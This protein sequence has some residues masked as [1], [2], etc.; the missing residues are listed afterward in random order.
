MI[1]RWMTVFVLSFFCMLFCAGAVHG[2]ERYT[3]E[4]ARTG[5]VEIQTGLVTQDAKFHCVKQSCG[6]L[7]GNSSGNVY[8]VTTGHSTVI[9]EDEKKTFCKVH[10]IKQNEYGISESIRLTIQGDVATEVQI[11]AKSEAQDFC[12]LSVGDVIQEKT[13]LRLDDSFELGEGNKVYALGFPD[14]PH[15]NA[16]YGADEVEIRL[17]A[18]QNFS[19]QLGANSVIQH[20]AAIS[21]GNSGGP[22]LSEDGYVIGMNNV[23]LLQDG[24]TAYVS[25]P[26]SEIIH[27][28]DNYGILY[29]SRKRDGIWTRFKELYEECSELAQQK[30]YESNSQE[31]LQV[32]LQEAETMLQEEHP[33]LL[34]LQEAVEKLEHAK[35]SLTKKAGKMKILMVILAG[36]FVLLFVRFLYLLHV[37][38]RLVVEAHQR[39]RG[40][41]C[42]NQNENH[43][44]DVWNMPVT[45]VETEKIEQIAKNNI[46][47]MEKD[48]YIPLEDENQ[49]VLLSEYH[50]QGRKRVEMN[51]EKARLIR[52]KNHQSVAILKIKFVLGKGELADY[53]ISENKAV[54]RQH[55]FILWTE[56]GYYIYDLNSS[57][58]TFVNGQ[59]VGESGMKLNNRDKVLLADESFQFIEQN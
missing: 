10:K 19:Q 6:F 5:V 29:E 21:M 8:L 4:D 13:A 22:L 37:K 53:V 30:G 3:I 26:I 34:R 27:I 51:E 31:Q 57:N 1:K 40:S 43:E 18:V 39:Q 33:E 14:T 24:T 59:R 45:S 48:L 58:G 41:A 15:V 32:V 9:S 49:T 46:V 50:S 36:I 35:A 20:S 55:A 11:V 56:D 12:I 54:S 47:D 23:A 25:L 16:K 17:G 28:L 52:E 38:K 42:M 44:P 2:E 7:I